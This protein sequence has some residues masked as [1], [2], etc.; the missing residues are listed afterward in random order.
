MSICFKQVNEDAVFNNWYV[1]YA[2][3]P[4]AVLCGA[5]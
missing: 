5:V 2:F 4:G 1:V 3:A